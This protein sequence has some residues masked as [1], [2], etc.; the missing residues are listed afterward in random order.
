MRLPRTPLL[1]A[2]LGEAALAAPAAQGG[3]VFS[4]PAGEAEGF[5]L[6][7]QAWAIRGM[8]RTQTISLGLRL[9]PLRLSDGEVRRD[10]RPVLPVPQRRGGEATPRACTT[11]AWPR[12]LP[13][14]SASPRAAVRAATPTRS[15]AATPGR[16]LSDLRYHVGR[17]RAVLQLAAKRPAYRGRGNRHDETGAYTLNGGDN[18]RRLPGVTRN[19]GATFFIRRRTNGTRRPITMAAG[20]SWVLDV[21]DPEQHDPQQRRFHPRARTTPITTPRRLHRS[22]RT[23]DAGR[24]F[25]G[26]PGPYGTFDMAATWQWNE[27]LFGLVRGYM[28]GPGTGLNSAVP[29]D[30]AR[31]PERTSREPEYGFRVAASRPSARRCQ[32]R[33]PGGRQRPDDRALQ[34]RYDG[35]DARA[36]TAISP[37]MAG[38]T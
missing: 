17:C 15:R 33:G 11:L 38:W 5:R 27:A 2:A 6:R 7:V 12:A 37:A 13:T 20:Q 21:P 16:Q 26:S 14:D 25:A 28:A 30:R 19:S 8:R 35:G 23:L 29:T 1:V 24:A 3:N 18:L 22:R 32:P 10:D 9:G 36:E 34:L 4:M 31:W